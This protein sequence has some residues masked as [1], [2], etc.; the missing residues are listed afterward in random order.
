MHSQFT[1][2]LIQLLLAVRIHAEAEELTTVVDASATFPSLVAH[3]DD[4]AIK[5][6]VLEF[7]VVDNSSV[8][9]GENKSGGRQH[10]PGNHH[11]NTEIHSPRS[12]SSSFRWTWEQKGRDS[13]V[14]MEQLFHLA[15]NLQEILKRNLELRHKKESTIVPMT[16]GHCDEH[17]PCSIKPAWSFPSLGAMIE[18]KGE[19]VKVAMT[20]DQATLEEIVLY[21]STVAERSCANPSSL[22]WRHPCDDKGEESEDESS[23]KNSWEGQNVAKS[24]GLKKLLRLDR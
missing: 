5:P 16:N 7:R 24:L 20:V 10:K 2:T 18:G 19:D 21:A 13:G 8:G 4:N 3:D 17:S 11:H 9:C 15:M 22:K 6:P 12:L 14:W 1:Q 23:Q